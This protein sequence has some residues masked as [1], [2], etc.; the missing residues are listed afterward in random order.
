MEAYSVFRDLAIIIVAAKIFAILARKCKAPQVVGEIVA[1]LILG[2]SVLG[3]V[4]Q[5]NFILQIYLL[6]DFLNQVIGKHFCSDQT[7][8]CRGNPGLTRDINSGNGMAGVDFV[9]NGRIQQLL[10]FGWFH[11]LVYLLEIK[12]SLLDYIMNS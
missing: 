2:P 1:G 6:T 4:Q 3:L 9:K 10:F 7:N 12:E 5:S 8:S 11:N